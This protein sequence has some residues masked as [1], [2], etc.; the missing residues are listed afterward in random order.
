MKFFGALLEGDAL[1]WLCLLN[2]VGWEVLEA[3]FIKVWCIHL[4]PTQAMAEV[5]KL[6][7]QEDD[8]V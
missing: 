4:L 6:K 5:G 1:Q 2:N 7:Q 8:S 3:K